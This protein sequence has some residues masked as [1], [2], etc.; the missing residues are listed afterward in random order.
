M[1]A[2]TQQLVAA[3]REAY[4]YALEGSTPLNAETRL[5]VCDAACDALA[6]FEERQKQAKDAPA[7][8]HAPKAATGPASI[9]GHTTEPWDTDGEFITARPGLLGP[10]QIACVDT[11]AEDAHRIVACVNACA[12]IRTELLEGAG[13][14]KLDGDPLYELVRTD[15]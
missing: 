3:L 7:G 4:S 10:M 1:D 2:L 14:V 11:T 13:F 6:A 12:G 15:D 5:Y 9:E 8:E